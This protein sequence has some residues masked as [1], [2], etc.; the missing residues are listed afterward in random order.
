MTPSPEATPRAP[1]ADTPLR[2]LLFSTLYPS[3]VRPGHGVFV[4]TRLRE[5]L[6]SGPVQARVVA[7]VP[8]FPSTDPRHGARALMAATPQAETRHGIEVLHPRYPLLPKVGQSLHPF[9]LA[10]GALRSVRRLQ[11]QGFDFDLIDAHFYYPDG[12]AA[13]LLARWL[14]KPLVI[15]AR[16]SDLNVFGRDRVPR[17]LMRWAGGVATASIGVCQALV[18][19]LRG[20]G[21]PPARLHVVRNGVDTQ[22]FQ[23]QPQ[24]AAR[25]ALGLEGAPLLLS[26][27]HLVP[28]KG[29]DI[30]LQ[31]LAQLLPRHPG[32]RLVFV[33][34]GPLR[35]ALQA[36]A[37]ALGIAA[38]VHFAGAVPNDQLAAWYS[39]ADLLVLASR[40]EGWANVLLEAMA[41]GT[42]VVATAVGGTAEVVGRPDVGRVVPPLDPAAL[43]AGIESMLAAAP[44]RAAVRAYAQAFGWD[45]TSAMQWRLFREVLT[46]HRAGQRGQPLRTA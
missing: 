38:Q 35:G 5:L 21:L 34:D 18:D 27:G 22:R 2:V 7:P 29:H 40:S 14:G 39:A 31:A 11:R 32:A 12:V 10:L 4:E 46:R 25:A 24:A 1:A 19:V 37:Q 36:Q 8:W 28:V 15:T 16:G 41:C 6:R 26:V 17:A 42:P 30:A 33:G 44:D 45:E 3:S 9:G 20:W 13:A 43:A 23:P